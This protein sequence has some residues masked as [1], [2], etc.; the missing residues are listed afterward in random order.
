MSKRNLNRFFLSI[1]LPS[2]LAI[3]L[4]ILSIFVVILPSFERNSM[5]G[6]KE[7]I[8]ELTRSV[9]SLIE[10]YYQE[11]QEGTISADSA[12]TLAIERI[13]QIRYGE[14]LK[15]YFWIIDQQPRMIMHPYRPELIGQDLK[16]YQDPDGK[17]LFV[18]S[19]RIVKEQETGFLDYMWQWKD[20]STRIVPKL[21]FVKAY[22]PWN[23]IVGTGIYL[24]DV[25]SEISILKRRLLRVGLLI[26]LIISALL[27]YMI[28]QSLGIE[29][30]RR[31]AEE[32]LR[33]SREKY[34][35]LVQASNQGTLMWVNGS[36]TF[37]NQKFSE[38]AGYGLS[39]MGKLGFEEIFSLKWSELET[40]FQ[41]PTQ[42][43]SL[44][45]TIRCKDGTT[46]EV[47]ITASRIN[48]SEQTGYIV[49]IKEVSEKMQL[50]KE[51]EKL[52]E[53]LQSALTMMNLPL[54][55]FAREAKRCSADHSIREAATLMARKQTDLLFVQHGDRI[56][57]V[58][59]SGDLNERVLVA[60]LN[61]DRNIMEIMSSPVI[62]LPENALL[63][64]GLLEMRKRQISH[65]ALHSP[66]GEIRSV[67]GYEEM[68]ETQNHTAGLL[69][70]EVR[71]AEEVAQLA[72]LYPRLPVIVKALLESG[73]QARNVTRIITSVADAIHE[74]IVELAMEEM[75][76][77]PSSFSF[78]VMGSQGRGEQ[79]LLTDQDNAIIFENVPEERE[80][81]VRS[82]FRKLGKKVNDDLDRVGYH[83]CKGG[84]MA[85]NPDWVHSLDTWK[86]LFGKWMRESDPQSVMDAAILFD[87]RHIFGDPGLVEQL[88]KHVNE[89]ASHQ[90]VFFYQLAQSVTK[91]KSPVTLFGHIKSESQD[92]ENY[93]D[94]KK[95]LLPVSSY[96]R[97]YAIR[98]KLQVTNS[99]ER[100][101]QLYSKKI[102]DKSLFDELSQAFNYITY[103]RIQQ[104]A[105]QI[106]RNNPPE[107]TVALQQLSHLDIAVLKRLFSDIAG[108]QTRL[109]TEFS[110]TQ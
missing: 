66:A 40:S 83:Y 75:G 15:D 41:D 68:I 65:I 63:Y 54:S 98:E 110:S 94:L 106:S 28:R 17:L 48:Y 8:S 46:K 4:Y 31:R 50:E 100:A 7:M 45:T 81:E 82:Y 5:N 57:G 10:E 84:I 64:E 52:T 107:N 102:F 99:L 35:T 60:G 51:E 39:E 25:R 73:S 29:T 24:E 78:M 108:L 30:R 55:S 47:V 70:H 23:W 11:A 18:E 103:L 27:A 89:T 62:S 3:G 69:I 59:N 56:V 67:V 33:L 20:D 90:P 16:D 101:E 26:T 43:V 76:P 19:V 42:S 109:G 91:M 21:S 93:L 37:S 49:I 74:R 104:Q 58:V 13:R 87:F 61:P 80:E 14:E 71:V 44:E 77:P 22:T 36:L 86:D 85:G 95:V 92:N 2:I 12:K 96:V 1:V 38:L 79:T 9:I 34:R 53:D 72:A 105:H 6:K 97:L 32:A 88:R